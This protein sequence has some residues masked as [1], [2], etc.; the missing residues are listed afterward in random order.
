[1]LD[2]ALLSEQDSSP[3]EDKTKSANEVVDVK[4]G[5]CLKSELDSTYTTDP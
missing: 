3:I 5:V 1:M 2:S 4:S